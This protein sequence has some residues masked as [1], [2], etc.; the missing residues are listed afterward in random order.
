MLSKHTMHSCV[1]T[2]IA[3]SGEFH[4]RR[5]KNHETQKEPLQDQA[6]DA[7]PP[8]KVEGGPPGEDP[9]Q[10]PSLYELIIDNEC[11]F[12]LAD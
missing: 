2:Y 1:S 4:I 6:S 10:D 12:L 5:V 8:S 11:V 7:H 9:P 3:F